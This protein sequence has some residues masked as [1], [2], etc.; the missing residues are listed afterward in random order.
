VRSDRT[1]RVLVTRARHQA[2]ELA[3][4]L[5][6]LGLEP[7]VLPVIEMAEPTSFAALDEALGHLE[8]FQWVVFTSAN[9]VE[10]AHRRGL[11]RRRGVRIAAIGPATARAL[12]AIGLKADLVPSQAVAEA[13][14]RELLPHVRRADGTAT[15]FLLVRAEEARDVLP[16]ALRAAGGDVTIAPTYRNVIPKGSVEA[17]R[18]MFSKPETMPDAITFTSS[19]SAHNLLALCAAAGVALPAAALRVSIGSITS[20]TLGELGYPPHAEAPSAS[21]RSLAETVALALK[22]RDRL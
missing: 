22:S 4:R 18:E 13:L 9:A 10:A 14:A 8:D 1:Y 20:E 15:R 16:D 5:R 19:S 12:E 11:S 2:S 6:E 7:V 17:I 3:E 21:V